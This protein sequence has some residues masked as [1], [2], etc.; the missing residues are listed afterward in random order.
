MAKR[1]TRVFNVSRAIRKG[2]K[3]PFHLGYTKKSGGGGYFGHSTGP[4]RKTRA[5]KFY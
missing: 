4:L 1:S 3:L 5:K 2:K